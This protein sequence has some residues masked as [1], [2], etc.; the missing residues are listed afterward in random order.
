MFVGSPNLKDR[1]VNRPN[2]AARISRNISSTF[3]IRPLMS[4]FINNLVSKDTWV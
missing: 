2:K 4:I 1:S 3:Q